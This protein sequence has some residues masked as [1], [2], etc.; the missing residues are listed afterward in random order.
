MQKAHV[1]VLAVLVVAVAGFI[2]ALQPK[3]LG[4]APAFALKD[5]DGRA[6]SLAGLKGKVVVLDF[7]A[8]WCQPCV[9]EIPH[10]VELQNEYKNKD[11]VVIGMSLDSLQPADIAKFAKTN[12]M[13]Y[14]IVMTDETTATA[15][16]ADEGLPITY[17]LNR[18]GDVVSRHQGLTD[19]DT[20][21]LDIR[22]A[23]KE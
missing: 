11:V 10:F 19:K 1:F 16:G 17:V 15:Y 18:N 20:F 13:N 5:L 12:G 7:W 2:W 3:P 4:P 21:E 14:P 8:T 22:K 6:I 23:L 9:V